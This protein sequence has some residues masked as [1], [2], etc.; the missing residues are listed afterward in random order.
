MIAYEGWA[1]V[2]HFGEVLPGAR[3]ALSQLR[4]AGWRIIIFTVR[5]NIDGIAEYLAEQE[6]PYDYINE[7]PAQPK[8]GSGKPFADV[9]VDDR[10]VTFRGDWTQALDAIEDFVPWNHHDQS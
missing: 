4:E 6:L 9:Y 3:E 10:A 7:N 2:D 8:D 1:G 5:G